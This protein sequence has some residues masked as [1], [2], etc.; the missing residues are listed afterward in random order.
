MEKW[1]QRGQVSLEPGFSIEVLPEREPLKVLGT[2]LAPRDVTEHEI[3]NRIASGWRLFWSLKSLLLN[4]RSSVK[5]RLKLFD[6][7][8]GSCILWCCQ[9]WTPRVE[10]EQQLRTARRSMLRKIIGSPRAPEEDYLSW[11]CRATTKAEAMGASCKVRDWSAAHRSAKWSWAGHVARR[12]LSSW[13]RCVSCWRESEWQALVTECG[14]QRPLRPS[15][16]RWI[17]VGRNVTPLLQCRRSWPLEGA[18]RQHGR[19]GE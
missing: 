19:V 12:P 6:S 8:V 2:A 1:K 17:S 4:R 13:V 14:C 15:T 10:E 18:R 16:R 7:T 9:S 5:R 11:I 3:A